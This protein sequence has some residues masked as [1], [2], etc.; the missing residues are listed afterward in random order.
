MLLI[1][2]VDVLTGEFKAFDSRRDP[3]S[4]GDAPRVGGDPDAVPVRAPRRRGLLGRLFSQ[5]PPVRELID[6]RPTR[7]GSS[8]STRRASG[9]S[10]GP[11][12]RS[13]TRRNELSGNL[14][15]HQELHFIEKIDQLL[16]EGV[17]APDGRFRTIVVR[18][19]EL[20]RSRLPGG[21]GPTS[22][23]NR[24]P[25][26][27][28]GLIR[29]WRG[30]RRRVPHGARVRVRVAAHD[31]EATIRFLSDDACIESGALPVHGP[32]RGRAAVERFLREHLGGGTAIDVT[33]KQIAG[34][35]VTWSAR[36][37]PRDAP[38]PV[39]GAIEATFDG[40]RVTALR[41][42]GAR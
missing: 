26:F 5:N 20:S 42:T 16:E 38:A 41:L 22:K 32:V 33:R 28:A 35:R 21:L 13:R 34:Q 9:A 39:R 27:I 19:I 2:A 18:V 10:R 36:W 11:R 24:D 6:A 1:G 14:S 37:Q 15:L 7:S 8:R 40:D 30:P 17:L 3:I 31:V 25:G 4:V 23:L 29:A 12:S